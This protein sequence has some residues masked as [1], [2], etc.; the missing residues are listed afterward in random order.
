MGKRYRQTFLQRGHTECKYAQET[1]SASL[2]SI[3]MQIHTETGHND[4]S[5]K[6]SE[7]E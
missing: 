1:C 6:M 2:A 3:E 7:K 4:T 5:V